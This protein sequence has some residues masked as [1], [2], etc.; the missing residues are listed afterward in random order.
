MSHK[1]EVMGLKSGGHN[2]HDYGGPFQGIEPAWNLDLKNAE[3]ITIVDEDFDN[4]SYISNSLYKK[5]EA[6]LKWYGME[7]D[8]ITNM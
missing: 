4:S 8:C 5:E 3:D 1:N 6:V 7:N 2:G